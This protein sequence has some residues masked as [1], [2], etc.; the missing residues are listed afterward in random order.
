MWSQAGVL[1][2]G[3]SA[4]PCRKETQPHPLS[5]QRQR[6]CPVARRTRQVDSGKL[7]RATVGSKL[8]P[9][10]FVG[11]EERKRLLCFVQ[12]SNT[13]SSGFLEALLG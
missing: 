3:G 1:T 2:K 13:H 5:G 9:A 10:T 11:V 4:Q 7:M 6:S 12:G 8:L